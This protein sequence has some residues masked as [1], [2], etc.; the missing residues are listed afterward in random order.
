MS[1]DTNKVTR[2]QKRPRTTEDSPP[3]SQLSI[4]GTTND[5]GT[6]G[7]LRVDSLE[8]HEEFWFDDGS[9]ILMARNTGFCA[10]RALLAAQSTVF[11]DMFSSQ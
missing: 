11:A 5:I 4:T 6:N 9:I 8:R 3:G 7:R 1:A 2:L 10:Y